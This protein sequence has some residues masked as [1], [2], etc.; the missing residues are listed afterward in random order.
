MRLIKRL[1]TLLWFG[2]LCCIM[3]MLISNYQK[4]HDPKVFNAIWFY[5]FLFIAVYAFI[6]LIYFIIRNFVRQTRA[7][8]ASMKM[9]TFKTRAKEKQGGFKAPVTKFK[10]LN[11]FLAWLF[12]GIHEKGLKVF[13]SLNKKRSFKNFWAWFTAP[14]IS[15]KKYV[16]LCF[17]TI[18]LII[19]W[20]ALPYLF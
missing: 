8:K 16:L 1:F 19:V 15:R 5:L 14:T 17:A 6:A 18:A 2:T 11:R 3:F 7:L 10:K 12:N 9:Y 4:T 20:C 13:G